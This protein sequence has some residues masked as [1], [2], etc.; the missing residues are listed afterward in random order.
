KFAGGEV[1][2][3]AKHLTFNSAH[4]GRLFH[5]KKFTSTAQCSTTGD[6]QLGYSCFQATA[7]SKGCCLKALKPN[8]TGCFIDDQ[9]KRACE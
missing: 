2:G 1:R 8:E 5:S 7:R 6:C 3:T 4:W 9:C